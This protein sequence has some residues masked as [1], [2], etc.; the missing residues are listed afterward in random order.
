MAT[1]LRL[2]A[3][4]LILAC[5]TV[6]GFVPAQRIPLPPSL[7]AAGVRHAWIRARAAQARHP[8]FSMAG[9]AAGGDLAGGADEARNEQLASLKK[10]FYLQKEEEQARPIHDTGLRLD[11]PLC[12]WPFVL[13]PGH[14]LQLNVWQPQYTLMF[15]KILATPPPH[16]YLHV[17]LP[18]GTDSL[19]KP[20]YELKE[21]TDAPLAGTLCRIVLAQRE[22]DSRLSLVVQG[23]ARGIVVRQTQA[24]PY[25]RGHV[26]LL[27]DAEALYAGVRAAARHLLL[28]KQQKAADNEV[29]GEE[30]SGQWSDSTKSSF[31]DYVR[32]GGAEAEAGAGEVVGGGGVA[33]TEAVRLLAMAAAAKEMTMSVA[34]ETAS[35]SLNADGTLASLNQINQSASEVLPSIPAD[36]A[37]LL[38]TLTPAEPSPWASSNN[39][40]RSEDELSMDGRVYQ[41]CLSALRGRVY[42]MLQAAVEAAAEEGWGEGAAAAD[43]DDDQL[44]VLHAIEVQIWLEVDFLL[45]AIDGEDMLPPQLIALL[46]P[47]PGAGWP[48]DFCVADEKRRVDALYAQALEEFHDAAGARGAAGGV[49]GADTP[50]LNGLD[51]SE[52]GPTARPSG[53]TELEA[54]WA[55]VPADKQYPPRLRATR[56]SWLIWDMIGSESDEDDKWPL[57]DVLEAH[58]T[59]DRLRMALLRLRELTAAVKKSNT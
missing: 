13:L 36:I 59:A 33:V 28:R 20:Q 29:P 43:E 5:A 30:Y 49:V 54:A 45:K 38:G 26:Q 8:C 11:M 6:S 17:L 23:L 47:A 21:G 57:Q 7:P 25:A 4:S 52:S 1:A 24:L 9:S 37:V 32:G 53:E 48:P 42:R 58:S 46:P 12:R 19:G 40:S 39:A 16:Y 44:I 18:G 27:P 15:E 51:D 3:A 14:Q 31:A 50:V 55:Y 56:L 34:Y 22:P 10:M 2:P 41:L 35:L